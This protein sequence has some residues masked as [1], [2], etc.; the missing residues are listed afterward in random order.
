MILLDILLFTA[1]VRFR[2]LPLPRVS[3]RKIT[4]AFAPSNTMPR[5]CANI[6]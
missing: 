1:H 4:R 3:L 2:G 6:R 5:L